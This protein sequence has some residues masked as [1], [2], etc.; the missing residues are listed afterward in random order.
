LR[1]RQG[2]MYHVCKLVSCM[3]QRSTCIAPCDALFALL[4]V[5]VAMSK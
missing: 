4:V 5:V 1:S 2:Q 3:L